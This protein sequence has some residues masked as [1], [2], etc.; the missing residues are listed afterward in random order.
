MWNYSIVEGPGSNVR[1]QYILKFRDFDFTARRGQQH[2]VTRVSIA[3]FPQDEG[4]TT[5]DGSAA[6]IMAWQ[7]TH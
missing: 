5:D 2:F 3:I 4:A 1:S 6:D 7:Y